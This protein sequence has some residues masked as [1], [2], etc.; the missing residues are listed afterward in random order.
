MQLAGALA[1]LLGAATLSCS[2]GDIVVGRREATRTTQRSAALPVGIENVNGSR[3]RSANDRAL[4]RFVPDRTIAIDRLYFGFK[5]RGAS[6]WDA[7]LADN[8]GGDGGVL[9]GLLL[10]ID[11]ETGLPG[12]VIDEETVDACSRHE[13]ALAEAEATPVL[14]WIEVSA[15]L[16][17]GRMYGLV[18]RNAHADPSNNFFS[19]QM[20]IADSELAGPQARNEL[21]ADASGGVMAL[22]PRE[23][24]AWSIDDG[25]SWLYGSA[26]G[27]YLSY[28]DDDTAHPATRIPQYGF[29]LTD[30]T[31][32]PQQPYY[33][34]KTD[35]VGC[36]V[37]YAAARYAQTFTELGGFS[38]A[39]DVGT[40][41]I[42]NT[43]TGASSA[44]TPD[45]GYGFRTCALAQP[46][47][48][49]VDE[50]HALHASGSVE[51]MRMDQAQR[52]L[53][54]TVGTAQGE[55]RAFQPQ[56][57]AGTDAKDV[58]SLWAN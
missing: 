22:D 36:T 49:A 13:Q 21:R 20:P 16:E 38:A 55:F 2:S 15:E 39:G 47:D 58:P 10:E 8:G 14:A 7:G 51:L 33:A 45:P 35:C 48:V 34:Y 50:S 11:A 40:L 12:A 27:E 17:A 54:P 19:F 25:L 5:L 9:N 46:V 30:G 18:V 53:F 42:T 43:A 3:L 56:P 24:V 32:L 29:R 37:I 44:C 1:V 52:L 23:H 26:N 31:T 41:T 28:V 4:L 57:A 6:C